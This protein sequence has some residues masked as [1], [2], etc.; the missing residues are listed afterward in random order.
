M[1]SDDLKMSAGERRA[2][3]G[4]AAIFTLRMMGLFLILPVFALYAGGLDGVTPGLIGLALGIY[5]LTQAVL[6]IPFGMASDRIGRKPVIIAGLL[7]FAM[8][9]MIAAM[10]STIEGVIIGRALQG[11]GAIGAAVIALLSDLTRDSQRTKAMALLGISIGAAF[12]LSILLGPVLYGHIGIPGIF[13]LTAVF[14]MA[15]I[16]LLLLFV[17]TPTQTR[18]ASAPLADL[19]R[20]LGDGALIRLD[21]GI[22]VLHGALMASFVFVPFA[23]R[24]LGVADAD[25]WQIYLPVLGLSLLIMVP[26]LYFAERRGALRIVLPGSVALLALAHVVLVVAQDALPIFVF[27]LVLFFGAF[28]TLEALM[29]SLVSRTAP[30]AARGAAMGVYN[31]A[32]F[33]GIFAGGSAGGL[34][35]GAYGVS[36]IA[37]FSIVAL[38]IWFVAALGIKAPAPRGTLGESVSE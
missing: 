37:A 20:V 14:A 31:S 29:P 34:L 4:L 13:W 36:G 2:T 10:A 30:Q 26:A 6:Q 21:I 24:G 22:F 27:G 15:A 9:S 32:Q 11:A 19:G 16:A 1:N 33:I 3:V 38:A 5:G 35:Y 25:H 17:P 8:G 23:L 12:V 28:N 7:I 18:P